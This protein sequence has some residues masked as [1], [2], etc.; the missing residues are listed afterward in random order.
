MRSRS[1]L[2]KQNFLKRRTFEEGRAQIDAAHVATQ[3]LYCDTLRL[4][5][6]CK[7][8]ACKRHR[9]CCGDA[10]LCLTR[11]LIHVPPSKRLRAREQV[12][13]GGT[14]RIAP[15]T[16]VEWS[17]RRCDLRTLLEWK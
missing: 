14:R 12:I 7:R 5:R 9:H 2:P 4:W 13:A 10:A 15:A 1:D 8:R 3:R 11:G 16:H 6:R 17:I